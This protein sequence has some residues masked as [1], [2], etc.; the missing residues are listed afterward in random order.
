MGELQIIFCALK[1]IGKLIQESG[2]DQA[3]DEA[4]KW[5]LSEKQDIRSMTSVTWLT[6]TFLKAWLKYDTRN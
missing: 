4:C 6:Y 2:L 1:V 3:F 5:I